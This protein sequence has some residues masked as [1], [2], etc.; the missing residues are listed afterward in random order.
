MRSG[1]NRE[2]ICKSLDGKPLSCTL[3][4]KYT[5]T[6]NELK[7]ILKV[8]VHGGQSAVVKKTTVGL[9]AQ[10]DFHE[11][12]RRICNNTLQT[13][14]NSTSLQNQLPR[15]FFTS[16]STTNM[17]METTETENAQLEQ[18]APENQ[19]GCHQK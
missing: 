15:N 4:G 16:L 14:K 11:V 18:E 10:D 5:V 1:E 7:T 12:K 13:A 2:N 6:L 3:Y 17:D 8:S 19:V 9:M